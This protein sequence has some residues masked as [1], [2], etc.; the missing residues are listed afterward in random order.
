MAYQPTVGDLKRAMLEL[1]SLGIQQ[2]MYCLLE[3]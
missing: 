1:E 3:M 2:R